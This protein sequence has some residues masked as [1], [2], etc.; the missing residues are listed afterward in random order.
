MNYTLYPHSGGRGWDCV[1]GI[2]RLQDL[3]GQGCESRSGQEIFCLR[4]TSLCDVR[5][6]RGTRALTHNYTLH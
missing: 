4:V 6:K 2:A 1:I 5:I 3:N